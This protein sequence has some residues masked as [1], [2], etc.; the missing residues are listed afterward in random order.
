MQYSRG[1]IVEIYF[2]LPDNKRQKT[3]PAIIISNDNVY[4]KDGLYIVVMITH[5]KQIDRYTFEITNDMLINE[6]D[7]K[8]AQA[9]CHLLTNVSDND[10]IQNAHRNK[11][12]K[13]AVDRLV[14]RIV[15]TS[16]LINDDED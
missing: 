3:H 6:S 2:Q 5:M 1:E 4:Q 12:I 8:Y 9:R 14:C 16:L 13:R 15:E 10:I 11:M 7:G